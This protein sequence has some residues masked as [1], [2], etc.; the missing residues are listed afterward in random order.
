[1]HMYFNIYYPFSGL[2]NKI[3]LLPL[4]KKM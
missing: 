4:Q 1:M 2:L 3:F